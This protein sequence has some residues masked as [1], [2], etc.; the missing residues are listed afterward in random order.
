[1]CDNNAVICNKMCFFLRCSIMLGPQ[2]Q[3]DIACMFNNA[4]MLQR[5]NAT[6]LQRM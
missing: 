6:T 2:L 1:M 5:Y 4:T 3:F